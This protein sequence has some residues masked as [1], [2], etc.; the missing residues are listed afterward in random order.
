M[1][2]SS[3]NLL[4]EIY[5]KVAKELS[6]ELYSSNLKVDSLQV[7]L[8]MLERKM[9]SLCTRNVHKREKRSA[10]KLAKQTKE[11]DEQ[12]GKM[13]ALRTENAA[14]KHALQNES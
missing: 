6:E 1:C 5:C 8:S 13:D 10:T 3:F 2:S 7:Q 11:I 14:L 12:K 4:R 9:G